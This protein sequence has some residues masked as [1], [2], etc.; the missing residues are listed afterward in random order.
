VTTKQ[1]TADE[2]AKLT[3]DVTQLEENETAME[4]ITM[5]IRNCEPEL[6]DGLEIELSYLK[7]DTLVPLRARDFGTRR[8]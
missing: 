6:G 7:S 8:R 5:Q 3:E 2:T 4:Q 1:F